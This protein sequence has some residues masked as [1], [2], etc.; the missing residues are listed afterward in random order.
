M[1]SYI[2][3]NEISL[4]ICL[5]KNLVKH[6]CCLSQNWEVRRRRKWWRQT[7]HAPPTAAKWV[8]WAAAAAIPP[9]ASASSASTSAVPASAASAAAPPSAPGAPQCGMR[10]GSGASVRRAGC[11]AA[12]APTAHASSWVRRRGSGSG[13]SGRSPSRYDWS[14]RIKINTEEKGK[15]RRWCLGTEYIQLFCTRT[16]WRTGWNAPGLFEEMDEI[17]LFFKS[18]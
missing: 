4:R 12:P 17:I 2:R 6:R 16:I 13:G 9:P 3:G 18:S 11:P 1:L 10:Q 15:G 14:H 5:F 8:S 7:A